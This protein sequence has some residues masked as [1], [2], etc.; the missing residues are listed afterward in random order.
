MNSNL[1]VLA[2][3]TEPRF[4]IGKANCIRSRIA[5]IGYNALIDAEKSFYVSTPTERDAFKLEGHLHYLFDGSRIDKIPE[6]GGSEWFSFDCIEEVKTEVEKLCAIKGFDVLRGLPKHVDKPVYLSKTKRI[7]DSPSKDDKAIHLLGFREFR[8]YLS[9]N[10]GNHIYYFRNDRLI[11]FTEKV[12]HDS[13]RS[14]KWCGIYSLRGD[15]PL[16][17]SYGKND[18]VQL[19]IPLPRG[20]SSRLERVHL[21]MHKWLM[22]TLD[23]LNVPD[24]TAQVMKKSS[25]SLR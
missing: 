14:F 19:Q 13:A 20:Y 18:K 2:H 22:G 10:K 12:W 8:E 24:V 9:I 6:D 15:T 17:S 11:I 7:K 4:K 3:T 25:G 16:I 23:N 1:Y 21:R 5:S